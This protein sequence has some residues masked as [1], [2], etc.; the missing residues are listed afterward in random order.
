M[1]F[2]L[3]K[4]ATVTFD[5]AQYVAQRSAAERAMQS[6]FDDLVEAGWVFDPTLRQFT[7]PEQPGVTISEG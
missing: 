4:P 1:S 3:P 5:P 6:Y 7:H 2:F